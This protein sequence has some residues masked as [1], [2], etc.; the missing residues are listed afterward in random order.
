MKTARALYW[1][2]GGILLGLGVVSIGCSALTWERAGDYSLPG[3]V[4]IIGLVMAAVGSLMTGYA[5]CQVGMREVLLRRSLR[6]RADADL[7]SR[8]KGGNRYRIYAKCVSPVFCE[9]VWVESPLLIED[10]KP[11][12]KNGVEVLFDPVRGDRYYMLVEELK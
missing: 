12:L 11:Y 3:T 9:E 2:R 1:R 7:V 4:M 10:P 8:K 6:V 5:L